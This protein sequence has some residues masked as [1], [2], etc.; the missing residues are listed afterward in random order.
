MAQQGFQNQWVEICRE[1]RHADSEGNPRALDAAFFEQVVQS[2]D[3]GTHEAPL[4]IGHPA[5]NAPAFGWVS[6]LKYADGS[7]WAKFADTDDE[8]EGMVEAG[9]FKKR[10]ASF[11][12]SAKGPGLRHVGFLGAQPPAVKGLRNIQ[13]AAGNVPTVEVS[14]SEDI[15]EKTEEKLTA[16]EWLKKIFGGGNPAPSPAPAPASF[17]E[18][19]AKRIADE[20]AQ[21]AEQRLK[22]EFKER[23]DAATAEI[24]ALKQQVAAQGGNAQRAGIVAFVESLGADKCPPAF[25]RAGLVE[26]LEACAVAD[27]GDKEPAVIAFSEGEGDKRIEH[28]FSR[29]D[30]MKTFLQGLP[31]FIQFGEQFGKLNLGTIDLSQPNPR[32]VAP[33]RSAM[34]LKEVKE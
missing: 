2:Y 8:F 32:E 16:G 25:K 29:L 28:K 19:D 17:S 6:A 27:A 26:F 23:Q 11:Y 1:G 10:S 14:F 30:W 20:A 3:A 24:N 13:F 4:V 31:S 22:A 15:M 21:A 12:L 9:K 18:A 5:E 7:L 33:L 34:G